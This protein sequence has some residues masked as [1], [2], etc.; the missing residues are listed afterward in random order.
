LAPESEKFPEIIKSKLFCFS[1][2][3]LV[4]TCESEIFGFIF[5]NDK[6]LM[7]LGLEN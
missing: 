5:I 3:K 7:L 4:R 1:F 6:L 2:T